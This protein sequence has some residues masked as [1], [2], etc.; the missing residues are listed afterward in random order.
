MVAT[1]SSTPVPIP[2]CSVDAPNGLAMA[3]ESWTL[4]AA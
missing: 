3:A 2:S 4:A 1:A